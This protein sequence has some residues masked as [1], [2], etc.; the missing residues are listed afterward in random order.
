M[1]KTY[2]TIRDRLNEIELIQSSAVP[3]LAAGD[4]AAVG[5][6][7][8]GPGGQ[9]WL[10]TGA[11]AT[12]WIQQLVNA[13]F[14]NVKTFGAVGDGIANDRVAIQS[15]I[16]AAIAAG[17]GAIFFP[18]GTYNIV[19]NASIIFTLSGEAQGKLLFIGTGRGSELAVS[20]DA[21]G[22]DTRL[23]DIIDGCKYVGFKSLCMDG[24]AITNP[25][26]QT[27]L[28]HFRNTTGDPDL[29]TGR[30]FVIDCYFNQVE[31]DQCRML[32]GAANKVQSILFYRCVHEA[33]DP[34][35]LA[36]S[37]SCYGFQRSDNYITLDACYLTGV[38]DQDIDFE[39]TG[40]GGL[41]GNKFLRLFIDG[42]QGST[43]WS[44]TGNGAESHEQTVVK[45]CTLV[46][47]RIGGLDMS[48]ILFTG[49]FIEY[50]SAVSDDEAAFGIR[51][52]IKNLVI[53]NNLF[54]RANNAS[55][56][57]P[58]LGV[59]RHTVAENEG[60]L[61]DGNLALNQTNLGGG[62]GIAVDA[63]IKL[64][65]VNNI[66]QC[67]VN[68][69][70]SGAH[71]SSEG[72]ADPIAD[73]L[74]S[75]NLCYSGNGRVDI[76]IEV[77]AGLGQTIGNLSVCDNLVRD[78]DRGV[79]FT[80]AAGVDVVEQLCATRNVL[81]ANANAVKVTN[82]LVPWVIVDANGHLNGPTY[83]Q[84][85]GTPEAAVAAAV[86][87]VALRTDGG[88]V[89]TLYVKEADTGLNTGWAAK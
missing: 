7:Y 22:G 52:R 88:A 8:F 46:E 10:K 69:N 13:P 60:N 25:S 36:R 47:G 42:E 80:V 70:G 79:L 84:V 89:T 56:S 71:I 24:S 82:D 33:Q 59:G 23:I 12:S 45:G 62:Q 72:A 32:G 6:R 54:L 39:P 53:S 58:A 41:V 37:R 78:A 74:I 65:I 87:S 67:M 50:T 34:V 35:S 83:F 48:T 40:S 20:G 3:P 73:H 15:T 2:S 68:T 30:C 61:I 29:E 86:G 63:Q 51:E 81:V 64:A 76:G 85:I 14:F 55:F 28:L 19:R 21:A 11:T 9:P 57:A 66:A 18:V 26:E 43:R 4:N 5:S 1:A 75:G 27:H 16:N 31:G 49:N 77:G 17:G 44:L 38:S